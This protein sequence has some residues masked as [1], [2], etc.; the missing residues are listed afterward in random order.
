[1]SAT[2]KQLVKATGIKREEGQEDADY[3]GDIVKGVGDLPDVEWGKLPKPAQEWYNA[4]TFCLDKG[5]DVPGFD[6]KDS[7]K[8]YNKK[9]MAEDGPKDPAEEEDGDN[10]EDEEDAADEA[11]S[12]AEEDSAEREAKVESKA[13]A[14]GAAKT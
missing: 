13:K 4:A 12:D 3:F 11:E 8:E 10:A 9:A 6:D 7:I 2:E 5:L 14:N 1:M